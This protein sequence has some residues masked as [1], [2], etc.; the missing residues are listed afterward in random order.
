MFHIDLYLDNPN[1]ASVSYPFS[2]IDASINA[3]A[4]ADALYG[5]GL[6]RNFS[7]ESLILKT[8]VII[9]SRHEL[10]L[11]RA[12][13]ISNSFMTPSLDSASHRKNL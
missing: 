4:D 8:H 11:K 1:Q 5:Q 12:L 3:D 9:K 7:D 10:L 13:P 2:S 6:K